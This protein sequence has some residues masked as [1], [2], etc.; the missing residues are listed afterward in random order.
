MFNPH[1]FLL[2][3]RYYPRLLVSCTPKTNAQKPLNIYLHIVKTHV[4]IKE[5]RNKGGL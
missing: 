2:L 5:I 1:P 4:I 3:R